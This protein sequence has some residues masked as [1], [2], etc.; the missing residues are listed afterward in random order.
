M[1]IVNTNQEVQKIMTADSVQWGEALNKFRTAFYKD[2]ALH[3]VTAPE[4]QYDAKTDRYVVKFTLAGK[5]ALKATTAVV[6]FIV[7]LLSKGTNIM[8]GFK[9]EGGV[10]TDAV[11]EDMA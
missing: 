1:R 8:Y 5:H 4:V 3:I 7:P 11:A 10:I 2:T 9:V 6:D